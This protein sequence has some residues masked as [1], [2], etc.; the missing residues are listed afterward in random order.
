M[1]TIWT[2]LNRFEVEGPLHLLHYWFPLARDLG[3]LGRAGIEDTQLASI[4][5]FYSAFAV[6][7]HFQPLLVVQSIS[8]HFLFYRRLHLG[9]GGGHL[10][11]S[12]EEPI[13]SVKAWIWCVGVY[14]L[15]QHQGYSVISNHFLS[16]LNLT[17]YLS[18]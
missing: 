13:W 15:I 6:F 11:F 18:T 3:A 9:I 14:R 17:V 7:K 5:G 16:F 1:S 2:S 10:C 12:F 4:L 8:R